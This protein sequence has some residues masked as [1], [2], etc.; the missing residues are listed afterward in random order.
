MNQCPTHAI[1]NFFVTTFDNNREGNDQS[2]KSKVAPAALAFAPKSGLGH[3]APS[4]TGSTETTH[5]AKR[6]APVQSYCKVIN[7][8]FDN[9]N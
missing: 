9:W 7:P 1:C 8:F 4:R 3:N 2:L 5:S 6:W